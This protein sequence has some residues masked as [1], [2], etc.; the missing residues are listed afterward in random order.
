MFELFLWVV[1][2]VVGVMG[3]DGGEVERKRKEAE[4]RDRVLSR[5]IHETFL[6]ALN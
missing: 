2:G 3:D 6:L 5:K 1:V 4:E